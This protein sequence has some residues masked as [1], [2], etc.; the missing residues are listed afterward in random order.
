MEGLSVSPFD[1]WEVDEHY[2]N[3]KKRLQLDKQMDK[4]HIR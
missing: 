3:S 2:L 1:L 4:I